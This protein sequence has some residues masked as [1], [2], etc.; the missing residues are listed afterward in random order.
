MIGNHTL[1][2]LDKYGYA[3]PFQATASILQSGD[4]AF[5]NL[6][7]PFTENGTPFE[8]KFTFKVHPKYVS[9]LID[10]GIDVV[11]LANNH[12]LD[13][14]LEGLAN[15]IATLD[16]AGI[17]FCGAGMA[18]QDAQAPA[19]FKT[20][21]FRIAVLGY[22]M[23][24][25]EEFWASD[26]SGGTNYP[27]EKNLERSIQQCNS[28]ADFTVVTFHW[29]RESTFFPKEYQKRFAHRSIDL[30]ADLVLG[31]HPHVL[32][33]LE[34]YK[35]RLIAY[36]LGNY[37]FSSYSTKATESMI[38]KTFLNEDGLFYAKIFPMC[39]DNYK[40]DFQPKIVTG[41]KADTILAHLRSYSQATD[42]NLVID[43][44]GYIWKNT[45]LSQNKENST[46]ISVN[47]TKE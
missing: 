33:G 3:Y 46:N 32:Q 14:G 26:T 43:D 44:N 40:I 41:A 18:K 4:M 20:N 34:I 39:V 37:A 10:A 6:E 2:Y 29:G 13:F 23:T 5:A 9:G 17:L 36:S 45:L 22:S 28:I 21:G 25:P 35:N 24:F 12:I 42:S 7:S 11:T 15:T 8:K 1:P 47:A 30:G 27:Y 31:H 38:L 16:S 19:I